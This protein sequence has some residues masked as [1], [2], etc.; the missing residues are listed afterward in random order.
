MNVKLLQRL[1]VGA[2]GLGLLIGCG[3]AVGIGDEGLTP[4]SEVPITEAVTTVVDAPTTT[5]FIDTR[6]ACSMS[7]VDPNQMNPIGQTVDGLN[8]IR[9]I[10]DWMIT[11]NFPDCGECEGVT[12]FHIED[13]AWK[14]YDP[15]Y[16]YCY[17]VPDD[18]G[19]DPEGATIAE[20][21]IMTTIQIAVAGYACDQENKGYQP[22]SATDQLLYGDVGPRVSALQEA[23]IAAGFLE[24]SADGEYGPATVEAVMNFQYSQNVPVDGIAGP[25]TH[26]LLGIAYP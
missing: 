3:G 7:A 4:I 13:N 24:D 10:G 11:Q 15:M 17:S 23:L 5:A 26:E 14:M 19:P 22:E 20:S 1:S 16:I 9:C 6:P 8:L 21:F 18:Y 25:N 12:P 2:L